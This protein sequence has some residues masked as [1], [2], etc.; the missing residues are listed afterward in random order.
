ML[1][2]LFIILN[3]T[4]FSQQDNSLDSCMA[5]DDSD[6][7]DCLLN[8]IEKLITDQIK[9]KVEVISIKKTVASQRKTISSLRTKLA[10]VNKNLEKIKTDAT[11]NAEQKEDTINF[12]L[13]KQKVFETENYSI[14]KK[15]EKYIQDLRTNGV[16]IAKKDNT[17][18]KIALTQ[19]FSLMGEN[20]KGKNIFLDENYRAKKIKKI[21]VFFDK[22]VLEEFDTIPENI[23]VNFKIE[24]GVAVMGDKNYIIEV[25]SISE[26]VPIIEFEFKK[27]KEDATY[28]FI[29][30]II[31]YPFFLPT[32]R[33]NKKTNTIIYGHEVVYEN[34]EIKKSYDFIPKK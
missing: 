30:E 33:Y 18:R 19:S 16:D 12:Y 13:E 17:M 10:L 7:K 4:V 29:I 1:F 21:N 27:Y 11:L 8:L 32:V 2:V 9:L 25:A 22:T 24:K 31:N 23:I 3:I 28:T 15:F 6:R 14:N 20:K 34:I 26:S 5:L